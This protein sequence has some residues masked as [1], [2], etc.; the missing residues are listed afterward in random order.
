MG[1]RPAIHSLTE[2]E[3]LRN[4]EYRH[5]EYIDGQAVELNIGTSWHSSIQVACVLA[6]GSFLRARGGGRVYVELH[7][8]LSIGGRL[9]YR[10]PDVAVILGDGGFQDFRYYEGAPDFVIEIR[11]PEDRIAAQKRKIEDYF[12]N[13]CRLAW[14]IIP[15]DRSVLVYAPDA[16]MRVVLEGA[17]LDLDPLLPGFELEVTEIFA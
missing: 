14:L 2:E 3:Y 1:S 8:R 5:S 15:E 16:P 9:R 11:S 10:L 13:G 7:C 6:L 4:S 17:I 12:A